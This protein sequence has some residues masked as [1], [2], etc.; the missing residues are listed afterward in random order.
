[1]RNYGGFLQEQKTIIVLRD[2]E[3]VIPYGY[4]TAVATV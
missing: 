4:R 1:M 2:D 3:D